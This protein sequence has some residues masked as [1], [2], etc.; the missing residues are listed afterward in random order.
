[1]AVNTKSK[2]NTLKLI[3]VIQAIYDWVARRVSYGQFTSNLRSESQVEA[4][5]VIIGTEGYSLD[6]IN[7]RCKYPK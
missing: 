3:A 4:M 5:Y 6:R 7:N 1:M 2:N